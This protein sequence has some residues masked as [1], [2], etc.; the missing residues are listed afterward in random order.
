MLQ[1]VG[2]WVIK[3]MN[4]VRAGKAVVPNCGFCETRVSFQFHQGPLNLIYPL[5]TLLGA[6]VTLVRVRFIKIKGVTAGL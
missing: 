2:G 4:T 5:A 6:T 1:G 3:L